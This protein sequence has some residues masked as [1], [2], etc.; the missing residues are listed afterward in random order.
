LQKH[1]LQASWA[2]VGSL[3]P[4]LVPG[5][6]AGEASSINAHDAAHAS[7]TFQFFIPRRVFLARQGK[8]R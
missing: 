6:A 2:R 5:Q 1:E 8:A 7:G 4:H 3:A